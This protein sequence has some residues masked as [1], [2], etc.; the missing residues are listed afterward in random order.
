VLFLDDQFRATV[1]ALNEA[2]AV[3]VPASS[4]GRAAE[5]E[6]LRAN[7][8]LLR[9][10]A[11]L[12]LTNYKAARAAFDD[13]LKHGP[14]TAAVWR[15]RAAVN[16]KL[17]DYKGVLEDCTHALGQEKDADTFCLRGCAYLHFHLPKLAVRDFDEALHLHPDHGE[18]L[19]WR[20]L[21]RIQ[22]GEDRRGIEDARQA[23]KR[24]PQS[25]E[26]HF[27][28]ARAL[29]MAADAGEQTTYR[30]E[31][32]ALLRQA[33]ELIAD[34]EQRTVFWLGRVRR[35]SALSALMGGADFHALDQ[36]FGRPWR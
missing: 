30:A 6:R 31:A 15:Q 18:A 24:S 2:L 19:A 28:A 10:R 36:R 33:A 25:A 26:V 17:E 3:N 8:H 29:A 4:G 23:V 32:L 7:T 9:A 11:L 20:G 21:A 12:K 27:Q 13:Y 34:S 22:N 14:A 5:H 16:L 1:Q 35:D